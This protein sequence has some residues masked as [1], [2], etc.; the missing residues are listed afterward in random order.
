[1]N[2]ALRETDLKQQYNRLGEA[3]LVGI[4]LF[5]YSIACAFSVLHEW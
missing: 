4:F 5:G 1:M 2:N 3:I